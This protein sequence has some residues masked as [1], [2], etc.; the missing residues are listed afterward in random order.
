MSSAGADLPDRGMKIIGSGGI[1][2]NL[3]V[4]TDAM[5]TGRTFARQSLTLAGLELLPLIFADCSVRLHHHSG[6][7]L[8]TRCNISVNSTN[9][10]DVTGPSRFRRSEGQGSA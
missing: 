1:T 8:E 10:V 9:G 4:P 6:A 3:C 7:R 5:A 2:T